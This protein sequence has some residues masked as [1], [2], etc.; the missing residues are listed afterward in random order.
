MRQGNC[1]SV[2]TEYEEFKLKKGMKERAIKPKKSFKQLLGGVEIQ[3]VLGY[4]LESRYS[5]SERYMVLITNTLP[6][7]TPLFVFNFSFHY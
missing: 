3:S 2:F 5:N 4:T 6:P 7:A 1:K